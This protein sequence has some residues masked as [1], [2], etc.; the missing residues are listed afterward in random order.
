M[1][2]QVAFEAKIKSLNV[3]LEKR[4]AERTEDL[5]LAKSHFLANMS[6]ELRT[7]VNSINGFTD[8]LIERLDDVIEP[9]PM[10]ALKTI[11]RKG[12]QLLN[13]ITTF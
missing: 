8:R 13:I 12:R 5:W 3:E 1:P 4:V 6:H 10:G 11:A 9:R 7:P 2:E